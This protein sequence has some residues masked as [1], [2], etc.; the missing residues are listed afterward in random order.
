[1][2]FEI[3]FCHKTAA[4]DKI[5]TNRLSKNLYDFLMQLYATKIGAENGANA[6]IIR[7]K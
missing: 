2:L 6:E 4:A 7:L 1:M 3:L 5:K